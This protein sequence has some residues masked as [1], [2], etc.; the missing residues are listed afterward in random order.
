MYAERKV[1]DDC[2]FGCGIQTLDVGRWVGLG[3]SQLL[4]AAQRTGI[5]KAIFGHLGED[6][7]GGAIH[8]AQH[9]SNRLS[10]Q[11]FAQWTNEWNTTTDG[12][13]EQQVDTAF[14]GNLKKLCRAGCQQRLVGSYYWLAGF[15]CGANHFAGQSGAAHC[16]DH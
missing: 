8:D 3:V 11:A 13:F 12:G 15:E 7:V 10:A 2:N 16:L 1:G 4:S 9:A 14:V 6:E 5:V